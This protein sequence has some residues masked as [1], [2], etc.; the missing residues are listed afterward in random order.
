MQ[1][2]STTR[3]AQNVYAPPIL[4]SAPA[5]PGHLPHSSLAQA[6]PSS[7]Q[8]SA[9]LLRHHHGSS[10]VVKDGTSEEFDSRHFVP[11]KKDQTYRGVTWD[12]VK[13][14]MSMCVCVCVC[15]CLCLCVCVCVC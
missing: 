12:K 15:L 11:K 10:V 13:Q 3:V 5:S 9:P 6:F 2:C 1:S 8:H 7:G 4:F 14:V